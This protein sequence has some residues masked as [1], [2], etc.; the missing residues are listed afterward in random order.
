[1]SM[2]MAHCFLLAYPDPNPTRTERPG[3]PAPQEEAPDAYK[4]K[5]S[6]YGWVKASRHEA[7]EAYITRD[8]RDLIQIANRAHRYHRCGDLVWYSWSGKGKAKNKP[9]Y[10]STLLGEPPRNC[11]RYTATMG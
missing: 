5:P 6:F 10:G 7:R 2:M 3:T 1:M 9:S 8:L 11:P 4:E